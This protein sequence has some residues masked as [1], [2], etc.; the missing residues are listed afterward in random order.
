MTP[1]SRAPS[2]RGNNNHR[3]PGGQVFQT[4]LIGPGKRNFQ[5]CGEAPQPDTGRTSGIRSSN[6]SNAVRAIAGTNANAG[7]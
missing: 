2:G 6:T 1:L 3:L 4:M 5:P 7:Q